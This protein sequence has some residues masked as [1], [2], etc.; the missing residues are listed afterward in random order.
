VAVDDIG[1]AIIFNGHSWSKP[2]NVRGDRYFTTISCPSISFCM[3]V[4]SP[5]GL[6]PGAFEYRTDWPSPV[7]RIT[8]WQVIQ[9]GRPSHVFVAPGATFR[10]CASSN[11]TELIAHSQVQHPLGGFPV[12]EVWTLNG[13]VKGRFTDTGLYAITPYIYISSQVGRWSVRL[14]KGRSTLISSSIRLATKRC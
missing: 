2:T 10:H 13:K 6:G 12:Q 8:K 5:G 9:T 3:A 4:A 14:L 11:V 7:V 1:N